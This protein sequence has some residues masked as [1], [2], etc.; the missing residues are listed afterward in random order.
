VQP[1]DAHVDSQVMAIV[2]TAI[3]E[4]GGATRMVRRHEHS[5]LPQL[6]QSA[7]AL[8][9]R[10]EAQ[11]EP[12]AIA[13]FLGISRGAV[14]SVFDG[15]TESW[16]QR[17]RASEDPRSRHE[18]HMEPEWS[19]QPDTGRLEPEVLAGAVARFAYSIVRR[20]Q[21]KFPH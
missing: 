15:P 21:G 1:N 6:V 3:N 17:L 11:Q 18:S 12:D 7:Y 19:G 5:I 2:T 13:G 16:L 4:L 9:L 10:E 14:D 8:V 20:K